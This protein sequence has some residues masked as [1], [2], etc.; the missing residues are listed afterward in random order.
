MKTKTKKATAKTS[1]KRK[2]RP[3][4]KTK[5]ESKAEPKSKTR[6][7]AKPQGKA[8][9]KKLPKTRELADRFVTI[10]HRIEEALFHSD[11][12][13][14]FN[15]DTYIRKQVQEWLDMGV[16]EQSIGDAADIAFD[17]INFENK[18]KERILAQW[19]QRFEDLRAGRIIPRTREEIMA[20]NKDPNSSPWDFYEVQPVTPRPEN[21]DWWFKNK[22]LIEE[23]KQYLLVADAAHEI[24]FWHQ[25]IKRAEEEL[26]EEEDKWVGN[27][28][29][30]AV[31]IA[32]ANGIPVTLAGP[33]FEN[34]VAFY[35]KW[36]AI[37]DRYMYAIHIGKHDAASSARQEEENNALRDEF[38]IRAATLPTD[39]NEIVREA[40]TQSKD[41]KLIDGMVSMLKDT[42]ESSKTYI[43]K[44]QRHA[45]ARILAEAEKTGKPISVTEAANQ[46]S[47]TGGMLDSMNGYKTKESL[48]IGIRTNAASIL[49]EIGIDVMRFVKKRPSKMIAKDQTG[50]GQ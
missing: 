2:S 8:S 34:A 5:P 3:Q 50:K 4:D 43:Q 11:N 18:D 16:P 10:I 19:R 37:G 7:K 24:S 47:G 20:H 36:C 17:R 31:Q 38:K 33:S 41:P 21:A 14:M 15:T 23:E 35:E 22:I 28:D 44:L 25:R 39:Y 48:D 26:K 46:L 1:T 30:T 42:A 13:P 40:R 29:L 6:G 12:D 45:A 9:A 32:R 27:E 49:R